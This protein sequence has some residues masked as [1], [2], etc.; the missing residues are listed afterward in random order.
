MRPSAFFCGATAL[1]GAGLAGAA[2]A[3]AG[4]ADAA[5]A[6][7][8]LA[9]AAL[10]GAGLAGADLAI[11]GFAAAFLGF[12]F[13]LDD[14]RFSWCFVGGRGRFLGATFFATAFFATALAGFF[15]DLMRFF[16]GICVFA[17]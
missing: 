5:L 12:T 7:A 14:A 11:M 6:G 4:L 13:A 8:A 2:L 15:A 17:S 1:A 9:G 10:A 16:E 3:G